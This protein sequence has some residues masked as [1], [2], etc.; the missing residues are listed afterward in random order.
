VVD[1]PLGPAGYL[2]HHL[3]SRN[4]LGLDLASIVYSSLP[5]ADAIPPAQPRREKLEQRKIMRYPKPDTVARRV[6]LNSK[7]S[8]RD[9]LAA[10]KNFAKPSLRMLLQ[11]LADPKTP[12]RLLA[13]A[14]RK[15]QIETARK[16]MWRH[17]KHGHSQADSQ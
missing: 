3:V 12:G 15:Y 7:V 8:H 14:A 1:V 4:D 9:R 17:A 6:I 16:E 10:L 11:L 2:V 13:L 5:L